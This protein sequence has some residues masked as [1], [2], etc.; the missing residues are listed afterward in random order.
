[1]YAL[2]VR[3]SLPI[4]PIVLFGSLFVGVF[5]V[6]GTVRSVVVS[7]VGVAVFAAA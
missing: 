5:Y 4:F 3:T 7:C 1:M 2:F 6:F